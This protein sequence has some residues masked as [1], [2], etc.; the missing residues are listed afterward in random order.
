MA[1]WCEWKQ[2]RVCVDLKFWIVNTL[3]FM[4]CMNN[5]GGLAVTTICGCGTSFAF[6][7]WRLVAFFTLVAFSIFSLTILHIYLLF[8]FSFF[9]PHTS[10]EPNKLHVLPYIDNQRR[11][12]KKDN[13]F[14]YSITLHFSEQVFVTC[15]VCN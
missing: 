1:F 15:F 12:K 13:C 2:K 14:H 11:T 7:S 3:L 6:K 10:S 8:L 4:L 9:T 5:N